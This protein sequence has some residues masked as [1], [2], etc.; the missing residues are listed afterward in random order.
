MAASDQ[1]WIQN[2]WD[3][4]WAC[5]G[6]IEGPCASQQRRKRARLS[7][8]QCF[9]EERKDRWRADSAWSP[10]PGGPGS[11]RNRETEASWRLASGRD[12]WE[13]HRDCPSEGLD[14]IVWGTLT[15]ISIQESPGARA[16]CRA[17]HS[18][19]EEAVWFPV[20]V[21]ERREN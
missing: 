9:T 14:G 16:R 17:E 8:N 4:I 7:G 6:N 2:W 12:R 15:M 10:A 1:Y 13:G 3:G 21:P 11:I 18:W 5:E 20:W 19:W